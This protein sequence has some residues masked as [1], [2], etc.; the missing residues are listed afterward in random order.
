VVLIVTALI[1]KR[2]GVIASLACV[3]IGYYIVS[4]Y[5]SEINDLKGKFVDFLDKDSI[6]D[7]IMDEDGKLKS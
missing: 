2:F 6:A 4:T 3:G 1:G 5:T 7:E